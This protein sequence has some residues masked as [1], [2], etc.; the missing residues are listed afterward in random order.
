MN[1]IITSLRQSMSPRQQHIMDR[2]LGRREDWTGVAIRDDRPRDDGF[3]GHYWRVDSSYYNAD[4]GQWHIEAGTY[5]GAR[6][7]KREPVYRF[8]GETWDLK[9]IPSTV[10]PTW[11]AVIVYVA[12]YALACYVAPQWGSDLGGGPLAGWAAIFGLA[13]IMVG[14]TW[15]YQV[16]EVRATKVATVAAIVLAARAATR[17]TTV[18]DQPTEPWGQ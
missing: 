14:W 12:A 11:W 5:L 3:A 15:F 4:T 2:Y 16:E 9:A 18:Y 10:F 1:G 13:S 8:T 7:P 17:G 6:R